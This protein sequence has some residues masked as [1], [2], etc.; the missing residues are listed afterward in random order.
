ML[1]T[2]DEWTQH[3]A[4]SGFT[5]EAVMYE[6][7]I[8][9]AKAVR[10]KGGR[11]MLF[12]GAV[13]D[14]LLGVPSKDYDIEIFGIEAEDLLTLTKQ[15]GTVD[16]VGK[17]FGI[18]ALQIGDFSIDIAT[19]RTE[20]S[21]GKGHRGFSVA[22]DPTLSIDR[23]RRRS[24]F[25]FNALSKDVIT[26]EALDYFGGATDLSERKLNVT[27]PERFGEDPLR[28]L[29][30]ARF[31]AQLG[32]FITDEA[33]AVMRENREKLRDLPKDRFRDEWK[34]LLLR[35]K[36]PSLGLQAAMQI[37]IFHE[38]HPEFT[39]LPTTPQDPGW[40][41][42]GDV[43]V[44]T[45]M[46]VDEAAKI[47]EQKGLS[48]EDTLVLLLSTLCHDLGKPG[49]TKKIKGR[50]RA[51][52]HEAAGEEPTDT[53]LKAIGIEKKIRQ[54]VK[55][56]VVHHLKPATFYESEV[57]RGQVIT[58]GALK[59]LVEKLSPATI[60]QLADVTDADILG[61]GPFSNPDYSKEPPGEW[62][63]GRWKDLTKREGKRKN[64]P[65]IQG[66][67]LTETYGYKG[68]P[69]IGRILKEAVRLHIDGK[70]RE[71]IVTAIEDY[72]SG[73]RD[74]HGEKPPLSLVREYL[75]TL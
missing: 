24:D 18:L 4:E 54:K 64:K 49:T 71:E 6:K 2:G 19:P 46:V 58:D 37:G 53:F 25:T 65:V 5:E 70:T 51:H 16:E 3:L 8:E 47:A 1:R 35:S 40:H 31:A 28:I 26:G 41:P 39:T 59:S 14:E 36:K 43:W 56:L 69:D 55:N 17:I 73:H 74:Q 32:L 21:T 66:R 62:L 15:F 60:E 10:E 13:R 20:E 57:K 42:E 11:A 44:H 12:G 29:R 33:A 22:T 63:V 67:D 61:R 34:K 52:E 9:F 30:A 7:I 23:A 48:E 72:I 45:L 27:D 50:W 75:S 38:L 68:G